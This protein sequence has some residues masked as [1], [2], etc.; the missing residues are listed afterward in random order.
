MTQSISAP[1]KSEWAKK[2]GLLRARLNLSQSTFG[3]ELRCSGMTVSRWERGSLEPTARSYIE[4]GSLAGHP[5]CWYFWERAGLRI[6]DLMKVLP[7]ARQNF[8][9]WPDIKLV[10]AGAAPKL[11][12]QKF[13]PIRL[14]NLVAASHGEKG[15]KTPSLN[16]A[17]V[18]G[19]I[20]APAEWCPNPAATSCLRI[21]GNSMMPLIHDGY[22]VVVDSCQHNRREL[23]GKLVI[24]LHEHT[25]LCVSRLQRYD[26]TEVL[27]S[28]NREYE[29]MVVNK[30][31]RIIAK[32]LWWIGRES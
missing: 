7:A 28:E 5:D 11:P 21:K 20:A 23:I 12:Q 10:H 27:Q 17:A 6:D 26:N 8:S 19:M 13:I 4:L 31:W 18:E 2:I 25:G 32:V 29:S 14:L 24:A 16:D 1:V 15:D 30:E 9:T 22:I 3:R